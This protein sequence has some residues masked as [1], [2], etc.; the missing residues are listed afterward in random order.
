L[1]EI[2]ASRADKDFVLAINWKALEAAARDGRT[3][4]LEAEYFHNYYDPAQGT[5]VSEAKR[6]VRVLAPAD[7]PGAVF[8]LPTPKSPP[9]VD[10]DPSGELIVAGGKLAT[11]IPVHSFSKMLA[12]I[13][14]RDYETEVAGI[15]V[16]RYES[17]IAG[18]VENPGLGPLH[19]EF[20]G[21]G[22]AYTSVYIS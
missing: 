5:A 20:D 4:P 8:F 15:P 21:N 13:E 2:E 17:T 9:G 11:V 12:A 6:G 22:H 19:T 7:V 3:R 16:L 1:L 18:E 10:I 14:A